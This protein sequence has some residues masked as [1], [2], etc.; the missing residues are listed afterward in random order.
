MPYVLKCVVTVCTGYMIHESAVWSDV[1]RKWFFLPRRA[2]TDTYDETADERRATNVMFRAT[3][4]F[5]DISMTT[6]GDLHPTHGF[7]AFRFVPNTADDVI[8]ALKSEED[9]GRIASY[10]TVFNLKGETLV[11]ET[12][13]GNHKFEGIEFI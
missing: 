7:S 1:H 9:Q 3:D 6:V 13:I 11:K 5:S 8:I 10:V 4:D 12:K 2:S